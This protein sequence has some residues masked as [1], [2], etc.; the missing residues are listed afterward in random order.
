MG[1]DREGRGP[2]QHTLHP[3]APPEDKSAHGL[4]VFGLARTKRQTWTGQT[5]TGEFG[6]AGLGSL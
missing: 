4:C 1:R 5:W 2:L 6:R 3:A